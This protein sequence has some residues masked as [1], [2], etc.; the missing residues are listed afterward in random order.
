MSTTPC[1]VRLLL[2]SRWTPTKTNYR[3]DVSAANSASTK[4]FITALV[5][6]L[7]IFAIEIVA[8]TI[9]RR[10]FR[11]IYEPKSYISPEKYALSL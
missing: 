2:V 6:N 7:A 10:Y 11:A 9:V 4:T 8:F 5:L 3:S 1:H